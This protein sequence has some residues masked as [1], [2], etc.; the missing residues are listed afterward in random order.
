MSHFAGIAMSFAV[1]RAVALSLLFV[2]TVALA[3]KRIYAC[4]DLA[5]NAVFSSQPCGPD[6]RELH[7]DAGHAV[8]SAPV[9]GTSPQ[10]SAAGGAPP[11]DKPPSDAIQ[12]ISDSVADSNCRNDARRAGQPPSQAH[13]QELEAQRQ[14]L[15][16]NL[17]GAQP[18]SDSEGQSRGLD[19]QIE[20]ERN[21]LAQQTQKVQQDL[22]DALAECDRRKAEREQH[23]TGQ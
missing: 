15:I 18:S 2:S 7:V 6:A 10:P 5:G 4:K 21:R 8:S 22:R 11:A 14:A 13:L 16:K 20:E 23:H 17:A 19:F 1:L 9:D 12:D 3:E